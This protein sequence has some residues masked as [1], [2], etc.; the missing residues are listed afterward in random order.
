MNEILDGIK[1]IK[2]YAWETPF[3]QL[4][5]NARKNE[6][7][8]IKQTAGCKS[9]NYAFF[10]TSSRFVL[11]P[12]FLLMVLFGV[13]I[14]AQKIFL[15]F[16]LF[17]AI[18]LPLTHFF[19]SAISASSEA[20][21]SMKRI[22][23]FLLL[24]EL[25]DVQSKINHVILPGR[26]EPLTVEV[27]KISGKWLDSSNDTI[28]QSLL[29]EF[30]VSYGEINI[31]GRISYASQEA[32]IF[33][34]SVRQNILMGKPLIDKRYRE[35][36]RVCALEHDVREWPDGD[37]TFVGEKGISLSGGQKS[38]I[39]LARCVYASADIYILD[40][41]L[42]A[43]DPHVGQQLFDTSSVFKKNA[44]NIILLNS[45][46]EIE[47]SGTYEKLMSQSGF[48]TYL[49][50]TSEEED[51]DLL[52]DVLSDVKSD[53]E[54]MR[55]QKKKLKKG[56]RSRRSSTSLLVPVPYI[57]GSTERD[58]FP[59]EKGSQEWKM[60]SKETIIEGSVSL[61][62]Y[63]K[64][65]VAGGGFFKFL[66]VYF[67]SL[68]THTLFVVSDWWL[69]LW[70]NAADA[71]KLGPLPPTFYFSEYQDMTLKITA[72]FQV[73]F[74]NFI[75][76]SI[77]LSLIIILLFSAQ[78]SVRQLFMSCMRSSQTL[79]DR[80][81]EKV[82]FTNSR[83][84]DLNP[85]GRILNRFSKDIGSI[86]ELLPPVLIDT[87][88]ALLSGS[89]IFIS[90]IYDE[91]LNRRWNRS[92]KRLEG[93]T[94]SPV[95][96]QLASSLDGLTTIR[97]MKIEEML[98]E[99]FDYLQDIHTSSYYSFLVVNRFFAFCGDL[100]L[101]LFTASMVSMFLFYNRDA[102][103]G[104]VGLSLTLSLALCGMIQWGLRQSAEVE[105]FMTSVERVA[106]YGD[107]PKE[108]GLK[109]DIKLDPSW[110]D[111]GVIEFSN[112]NLKYDGTTPY[113]LKGLSFKT[114]S[115]EK[116]GIVGRTGAG[117]SSMI[118]ALF[119]LAEPEGKIFID[120]VNICRLSLQDVRK[121]ISIIPQDPLLFKGTIRKNL[122]P[123][124]EYGELAIW[125]ALEQAKL[126]VAVSELEGGLETEVSEGGN[127]FS[128]GQRQ[129]FCL[130]RAI[131]RKNKVLIM[132]EAT[133]NVDPMTDSLI[134]EAIRTE[135]KDCTVFTIA[136]R[137]Y[138][139]MDSDRILVMSDGE[140]KELGA[141]LDLLSDPSNIFYQMVNQLGPSAAERLKKIAQGLQSP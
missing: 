129:L 2:M 102:T 84:F 29:G 79:H 54:Y 135:F 3:V 108:K 130:A 103:G 11:L 60:G 98:I 99:E 32:W 78:L 87:N 55:S 118:S 8:V 115:F 67:L 21:V 57:G 47:A 22:E 26:Y 42:S 37:Y 10:S 94:R 19:P 5:T 17:D 132:D 40:D 58:T 93:I 112:V 64:Y 122:D 85:N 6:M 107:L 68:I 13:E 105:N 88:W 110:P 124:D 69:R 70:T 104:D 90:Y 50:A 48:V 62:L 117:K 125:H 59:E 134:Q 12:V 71:R 136:H 89:G 121:K 56:V 9:F 4:V 61:S 140:I 39:N 83:F 74:F 66:C 14:N 120:G 46:G 95:F 111:K 76:C 43:V 138:T 41:P 72:D 96:S 106:E 92:V 113:V 75:Y 15:I 65:F 16:G 7:S 52:S 53:G 91:S 27:T 25:R 119:R 24:N 31:K 36:I 126:S 33:S 133:A 20:L 38:R 116:I 114:N 73:D 63:H 77:Y 18:K 97:S 34:G 49:E 28:I 80:M 127:N 81:F 137:L 141:P 35:V 139:V 1:V 45:D 23:E 123:F 128:V 44:N 86:D 82:A 131:L 51:S 101:S 109:G 100:M 30:P